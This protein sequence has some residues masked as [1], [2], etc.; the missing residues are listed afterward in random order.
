MAFDFYE[1]EFE[2]MVP[3]IHATAFLTK[4]VTIAQLETQLNELLD[5]H[6][7]VIQ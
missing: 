5:S 6:E 1:S 7:K 3:N 2:K 4:P